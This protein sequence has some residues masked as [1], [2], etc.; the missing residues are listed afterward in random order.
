MRIRNSRKGVKVFGDRVGQQIFWLAAVLVAAG[1]CETIQSQP[2]LQKEQGEIT[3][4]PMLTRVYQNRAAVM[5]ETSL[6]GTCRLYYGKGEELGKY[7]ESEGEKV[8]YKSSKAGQTPDSNT[9]GQ[10][11][12]ERTAFIHKVWL[13][14]LEAGVIYSYRVTGSGIESS[15]YKF[16]TVPTEKDR[17]RFIVYGDSRTRPDTYQKLVKLII[18]KKVDF[19]VHT[20]DL[21]TSGD[22]YEQWGPQFFKPSSGLIEAVPVYVIKGNHE[23]K[24]GNYERLLIPHSETNNFGFDYGPV[25]YFCADNAIKGSSPQKVLDLITGDAKNSKAQWKFVSYH[26]PSLNFGHHWS[27]WG[28][29]EALPGLAEAGVD[30]VIVGH[31]HQYERFRPIAPAKECGGSYVTYITSGGG[32]APLSGIKPCN[33]HIKTTATNHFCLFEINGDNLT[34]DAIDI[35][36]KIIDHLEIRKSEGRP[37]PQYIEKAIPMEEIG[38]YQKANLHREN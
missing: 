5:W 25:H 31:S 20:G 14:D 37:N 34:M 28:Y 12:V 30:F 16:Q 4:G 33:Y 23:G 32:G 9:P 17:V 10:A 15:V 26:R 21:V 27:A 38:Q 2:G 7:V 29:P 19:V 36:G 6:Q 22:S 3:K 13:E 11:G 18:D 35:K 1:S 8:Q 24:G